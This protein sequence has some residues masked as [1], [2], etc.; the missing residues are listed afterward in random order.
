MDTPGKTLPPED[1]MVTR[2]LVTNT[3]AAGLVAGAID[4]T[5]ACVFWAIRAD[6]PARRI[7]QSV[8][9]GI[10]GPAA[11]EGGAPTAVLGLALHFSIALTMAATYAAVAHRVRALADRALLFGPLYGILLYVIM[12]FVVVPLSNASPSA[13]LPLW[14]GLSVAVHMFGIGLPMALGVRRGLAPAG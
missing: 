14:V 3:A 4:I 6:V 9:S 2:R 7:L 1:F 10:M 13:R 11:F 12:N 8:A 5:Y